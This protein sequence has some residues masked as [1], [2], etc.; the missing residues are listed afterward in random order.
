MSVEFQENEDMGTSANK[1]ILYSRFQ[2][3]NQVP[4]V[5]HFLIRIGLAK[6]EN[7]ANYILIGFFVLAVVFSVFLISKTS[8]TSDLQKTRETTIKN[9]I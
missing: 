2:S 6:N 5:I 1:R 4:K 8:T 7:Q 9:T 3:S